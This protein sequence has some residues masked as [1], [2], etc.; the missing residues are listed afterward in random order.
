MSILGRRC[1]LGYCN[2][3]GSLVLENMGKLPSFSTMY[4]PVEVDP[5]IQNVSKILHIEVGYLILDYTDLV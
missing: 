2:S 5:S 4:K 1:V 3:V